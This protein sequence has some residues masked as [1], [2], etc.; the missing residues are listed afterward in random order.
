MQTE[1]NKTQFTL[2]SIF[3]LC[4]FGFLLILSVIRLINHKQN[5][6]VENIF[7]VDSIIQRVD[8]IDVYGQ[9]NDTLIISKKY[10]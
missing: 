4:F 2:R 3:L 9:D 8:T 6:N 5:K 1:T 10:F 7:P